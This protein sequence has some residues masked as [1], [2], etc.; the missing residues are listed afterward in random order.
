MIKCDLIIKNACIVTVNEIDTVYEKACLIV[1]NGTITDILPEYVDKYRSDN[2]IEAEGK[3]LMPGFIN[4]H[5]HIAM[6]YFRGLADDLPLNIWLEKFIWPNEAKFLSEKFVYDASMHGI[7]ELIRNG[8]TC[9]N[10]MYFYPEQTALASK[11]M[12]IRAVLADVGLDFAMSDFHNPKTNFEKIDSLLEM[13]KDT[14]LVDFCIGPHSIYACSKD[15]LLKAKDVCYKLNKTLHTHLSETSSEAEDCLT[16][17]SLR[18]VAYLEH[19][20]LLNDKAILAHG[21]WFDESEIKLLKKYQV[22]VVLNTESNLKLASGLAPIKLY[23]EYDINLCF[24]TD[25]VASN[26]NLSMFDEMSVTGKIHKAINNDPTFLKAQELVRMATINGAKALHKD[27][28][29]GSIEINKKADF[30]LLDTNK[31]ENSPYYD[32]YSLIV[33]GLNSSAVTDVFVN[34]EAVMLNKELINA[35]EQEILEKAHYYKSVMRG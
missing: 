9:F 11:K 12:R 29:I 3:I 7:A 28:E 26:N 16:K 13:F 19:L 20:G 17:H 10:D 25:G 14:D 33:Y 18:P 22:S 27:K 32:P 4:A 8:V 1:N 15:T 21:V 6:T 35:N 24:G 23:K 34:G 31:V 5:T 2:V 30:I